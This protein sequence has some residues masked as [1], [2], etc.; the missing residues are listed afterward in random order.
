MAAV[1]PK[2]FRVALILGGARSGKSALAQRLAE[3]CGSP[4]L[5]LA[6]GE[7]RDEEMAARIARHRQERGPAWETREVPL[8]LAEAITAAQGRF[9]AVL[10]DCLTLWLTNLLLQDVDEGALEEAFKELL[11][12]VRKAVAPLLLVSNEVGLGLVP[13]NPLARR[14]RDL[15][16]RLNQRLAS[17]A[18][19]VVFTAAGL[20]LILKQSSEGLP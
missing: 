18:D 11:A 9:R 7:P 12:A 5:Y 3:G 19:L 2:Q 15:A 8:A 4:L 10:V 16:G 14:F 13:D 20:P 6:T 17:Q 1:W